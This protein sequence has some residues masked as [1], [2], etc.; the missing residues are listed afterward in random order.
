MHKAHKDTWTLLLI[1]SE[2]AKDRRTYH[3]HGLS[4]YPIMYDISDR[5]ECLSMAASFQIYLRGFTLIFS[6]N[7][8]IRNQYICSTSVLY[9]CFRSSTNCTLFRWQDFGSREGSCS[10]RLCEQS[11]LAAPCQIRDIPSCST[12]GTS[13]TS[14]PR[15]Q[16]WVML[17]VPL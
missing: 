4:Y 13:S 8:L 5:N 2:K 9:I 1:T 6:L 12:R 7:S 11:P 17:V 14:L 15:A 16:P 3:E 10:D